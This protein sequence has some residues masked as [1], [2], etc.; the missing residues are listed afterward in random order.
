M[1]PTPHNKDLFELVSRVK[2]S[3][4]A[5]A[6]LGDLLTQKEMDSLAERWQLV[7]ML[8]KGIS[9]REIKKTL[10]V[11]ISKVTRG[12]HVLKEGKGGFQKFLTASVVPVG[13]VA[14]PAKAAKVAKVAQ[15][16]KAIKIPKK[17]S[18]SAWSWMFN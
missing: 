17:K 14:K 5:E 11:S 13:A 4:D 12:S 3:K 7:Q 6:L 15:P 9:Q 16:A 8:H 10:K 2:S 1:T 18:K